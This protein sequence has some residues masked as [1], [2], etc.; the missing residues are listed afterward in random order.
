MDEF[1]E[2][3]NVPNL[4]QEEGENLNRPIT[5]S[6]TEA[7]IKKLL[8]HKSPGP[9]GFTGKFYQTFKKELTLLFLK[10]FP[11]IQEEGVHPNSFCKASIILIPKLGK[12]TTKKE[13]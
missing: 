7:I 11:K 10:L 8:T 5:T 3:Y 2:T 1:L 13:N 12:D 6:G 9:D 4:N